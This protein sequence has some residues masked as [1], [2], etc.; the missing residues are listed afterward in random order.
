MPQKLK[1]EDVA[2]LEPAASKDL[3]TAARNLLRKA[4]DKDLEASDLEA[5]AAALRTEVYNIKTKELVDMMSNAGIKTLE[6]LPEGNA[7]GYD[8]VLKPYYR[9]GISVEWDLDRQERGYDYLEK[10]GA[11]DLVRRV[12]TIDVG[13]SQKMVERVRKALSK[14]KDLDVDERRTVHHGTLTAWLKETHKKTGKL[15]P[16]DLLGATVGQ[17][18][19]IKPIKEK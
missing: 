17:I 15:P 7:P 1:A 6:L 9:A 8:A 18:V 10:H 4:R 3:L 19:E 14:I 16:L 2:G 5:R 11:G 13:K 12:L